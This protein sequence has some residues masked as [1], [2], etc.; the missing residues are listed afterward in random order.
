MRLPN[1]RLSLSLAA[2]LAFLFPFHALG[3]SIL[4]RGPSGTEDAPAP[5]AHD[6]Q[7]PTLADTNGW[8]AQLVRRMENFNPNVVQPFNPNAPNQQPIPHPNILNPFIVENQGV[9]GVNLPC[10][11]LD[12]HS[13]PDGEAG[14][15]SEVFRLNP[16]R[17]ILHFRWTRTPRLG[18]CTAS[19]CSQ[20]MQI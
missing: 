11:W 17:Y 14:I 10:G 15:D 1:R 3:A 16:G 20:P 13:N 6:S 4:L 18:D 5:I 12:G 7:G 8:Q 9:P 19:S 2:I